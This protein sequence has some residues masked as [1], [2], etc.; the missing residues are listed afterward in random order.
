MSTNRN[1]KPPRFLL[2][3]QVTLFKASPRQSHKHFLHHQLFNSSTLGLCLTSDFT[4]QPKLSKFREYDILF[5]RNDLVLNS[6]SACSSSINQAGY[7]KHVSGF[8]LAVLTVP[9][10]SC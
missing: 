7:K 6:G 10:L 4:S 5:F 8:Y 2:F 3:F 1:Q 9:L